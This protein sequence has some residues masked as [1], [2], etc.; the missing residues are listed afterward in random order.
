MREL[1]V[2][3]RSEDY[4]CCNKNSAVRVTGHTSKKLSVSRAKVPAILGQNKAEK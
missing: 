2:K 4:D 3:V 1:L